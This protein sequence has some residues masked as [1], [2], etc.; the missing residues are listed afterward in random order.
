MDRMKAGRGKPDLSGSQNDDEG[1]YRLIRRAG[2]LFFSVISL[3]LLFYT[4]Y[5]FF[6]EGKPDFY[7][8]P[9]ERRIS[10]LFFA[11]A[12]LVTAVKQPLVWIQPILFLI[13][14]PFIM[15][16]NPDS[17]YSLGSFIIAV[18]ELQMLGFFQTHAAKKTVMVFLYY[19]ISMVLI[20]VSKGRF[21]LSIITPIMILSV[22]LLFILMVLA[23]RW[24]VVV[25]HP[26]Q[27]ISLADL[28]LSEK[29]KAYLKDFMKGLTFKE[30][31]FQHHVSESTIRNTFAHIYD[32][33]HVSD[34]A[35]LLSILS[36]FDIIDA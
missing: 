2:F 15:M 6:F 34:K 10:L 22:L 19:A 16:G 23:E 24:K 8:Y 14:L 28:N 36:D 5:R 3:F 11:I 31:A 13:T 32:K 26:R 4:V 30:I 21:F 12:I 1:T 33:F 27:R 17:F 35:G 25:I 9:V 7:Y 20:G 18:I 29:E